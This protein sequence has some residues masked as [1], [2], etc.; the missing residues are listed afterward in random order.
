LSL[1]IEPDSVHVAND[2]WEFVEANEDY[3]TERAPLERFADGNVMY[4]YRRYARGVDALLEAN[5]ARLDESETAKTRFGENGKIV[6]SIP[7][8]VLF[9]PKLQIAEKIREGDRDHLKWWLNRSE[10]RPFRSFR[11]KV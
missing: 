4:V 8:N 9:D 2:A 3:I 7:L 10:N 5:K 1:R 6:A 11:G